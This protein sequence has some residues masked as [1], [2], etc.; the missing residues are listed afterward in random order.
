MQIQIITEK[1]IKQPEYVA[2][3]QEYQKRLS[4]F[5]KIRL[6]TPEE[7]VPDKKERV[8]LVKSFGD[9]CS[10]EVLSDKLIHDMLNG[11]SSITFRFDPAALHDDTLCISHMKMSPEL[12]ACVLH[13]QLYRAFMILNNRTYH[14]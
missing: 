9:T 12:S 2:T 5:T 10:S 7:Y 1:K 11:C 14:K 13:E 8:I 3:I 6:M 4:A